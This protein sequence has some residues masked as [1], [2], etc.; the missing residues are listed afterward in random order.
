MVITVNQENDFNLS[1]EGELETEISVS[2][3]VK[4]ICR[5]TAKLA[6]NNI[7]KPEQLLSL[8]AVTVHQRLIK[9]NL[10]QALL[11]NYSTKEA[12]LTLTLSSFI[13]DYV[14]KHKIWNDQL[15][16]DIVLR[17]TFYHFLNNIKRPEHSETNVFN[18]EH[19]LFLNNQ[20][21]IQLINM[22]NDNNQHILSEKFKL[23]GIE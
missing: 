5:A 16:T 15:K 23:K 20:G 7:N 1:K 13:E 6:K 21:K 10:V 4:Q 17:E 2:K 18:K 22:A 8:T 12:K 3:I 9:L 19:P 14:T 11:E